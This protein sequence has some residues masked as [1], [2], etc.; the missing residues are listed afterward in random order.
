MTTIGSNSTCAIDQ[1]VVA[2]KLAL[3]DPESMYR[4]TKNSRYLLAYCKELFP[5]LLSR[6]TRTFYACMKA[7]LGKHVKS[8]DDAEQTFPL[9]RRLIPSMF[10]RGSFGAIPI[11]YFQMRRLFE[12]HDDM[13]VQAYADDLFRKTRA[14]IREAKKEKQSR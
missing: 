5:E 14:E 2:L 10:K 3:L 11:H 9:L 8:M 6:E 12:H 13:Q 1:I 7:L 4:K